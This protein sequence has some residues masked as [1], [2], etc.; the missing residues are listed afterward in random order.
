MTDNESVKKHILVVSQ[1]FYPEAFRI[2]DMC[3][4]WVRRGY[5]VTVLTGIPN[6]PY[7]KYFK[8][9]GLFKRRRENLDGVD[10]IRIPLIARG[11]SSVGMVLNYLSFVVSGWFW[12][13]F[14]GLKAD[15]VFNFEVSPMTQALVGVW[16][17]RRRKIPCWI[18]V[19]DLWPENIEIVTG[20][21]S[22]LILKP[23]A[24]MVDSIYRRCQLIFATSPSFV[25]M[26]QARIP[27]QEDKVRYWPQYAEEFYRPTER[28]K[29]N[30]I[31]DNGFFKVA[32]TGNVGRA[33]GL[34]IL[35]AAAAILKDSGREKIQF[36]IVGDGRSKA[37]LEEKIREQGVEDMFIMLPRQSAEKIPGL[38]AQCDA[39]FVSFM[40]N[41]LFANT[42]PAKLQSYMACGMPILAAATGETERIVEAADCGLCSDI[43]DA[44]ALAEAVIELMNDD[45][46]TQYGKNSRRY[47]EEHFDKTMLLDYFDSCVDEI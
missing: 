41:P 40:N 24:S 27:G 20:I 8:G 42:I 36:V 3:R 13:C 47:F 29:C 46:L 11:K 18:Y 2:N 26:I 21:H 43:G 15:M 1:Y 10:I 38:L 30:L 28:R 17:A 12:K 19:Q 37:A 32:F 4:E 39:A 34:E 16:Y 14:T 9:Y 7:G 25:K 22:K 35:P 5:R 23:I 6:Y 31:P 33:Q 44:G 45:R